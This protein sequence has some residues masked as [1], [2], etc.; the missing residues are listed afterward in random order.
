MAGRSGFFCRRIEFALSV[1]AGTGA[2]W[3]SAAP[4]RHSR[5]RRSATPFTRKRILACRAGAHALFCSGPSAS[6]PPWSGSA[7]AAV[8]VAGHELFARGRVPA[9]F[10]ARAAAAAACAG[11]EPG[12]AGS[13]HR[14]HD[15][16]VDLRSTAAATA[17][18][19]PGASRAIDAGAAHPGAATGVET[20]Y[21]A[22]AR[23][24]AA[25]PAAAAGACA[26]TTVAASTSPNAHTAAAAAGT[27]AALAAP[28]APAPES[29]SPAADRSVWQP[30]RD[31]SAGGYARARARPGLL[32][33]GPIGARPARSAANGE[34]GHGRPKPPRRNFPPV[35]PARRGRR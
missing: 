33:A 31:S 32:W 2:N 25:L 17:A 34:A 13:A 21:P 26:A 20:I 3:A 10:P 15:L 24:A 5:R 27:S 19:A 16:G 4:S 9:C 23:A 1:H 8:V 28:F 14:C 35:G 7:G 29:R 22:T 18:V 30:P 6:P 11:R 12:S